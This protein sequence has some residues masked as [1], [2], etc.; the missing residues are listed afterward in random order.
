M[1]PFWVGFC[2]AAFV[3]YMAKAVL[4]LNEIEEEQKLCRKH[5][6]DRVGSKIV[7]KDCGHDPK[8]RK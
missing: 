5:T 4:L 1:I 6:W 7:C 2:L 3:F 8:E